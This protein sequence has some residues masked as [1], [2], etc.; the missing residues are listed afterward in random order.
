MRSCNHALGEKWRVASGELS[1]SDL[2][3]KTN[4]VIE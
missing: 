1:E 2:N 3:I 4:L